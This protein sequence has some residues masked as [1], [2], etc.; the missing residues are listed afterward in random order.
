MLLS[1]FIIGVIVISSPN[2]V[3]S[4]EEI[5]FKIEGTSSSFSFINE[6]QEFRFDAPTVLVQSLDGTPQTIMIDNLQNNEIKD[7]SLY[8]DKLELIKKFDQISSI[9]IVTNAFFVKGEPSVSYNAIVKK[10]GT[11]TGDDR[12]GL[13]KA[14]KSNIMISK[15]TDIL[16]IDLLRYSKIF[17]N[18][19]TVSLEG[20]EGKLIAGVTFNPNNMHIPIQGNEFHIT[21]SKWNSLNV[22]SYSS[23]PVNFTALDIKG[24]IGSDKPERTS[25]ELNGADDTFLENVMGEITV[26]RIDDDNYKIQGRGVSSNILIGEQFIYDIGKVEQSWTDNPWIVLIVIPFGVGGFYYFLNRRHNSSNKT[27]NNHPILSE[28]TEKYNEHLKGMFEVITKNTNTLYDKSNYFEGLR[29]TTEKK[30]MIF[31]HFITNRLV[32]QK[33]STLYLI[34]Q[35]AVGLL[36]DLEKKKKDSMWEIAQFD[37]DIQK[38]E[39]KNK[40]E[41]NWIQYADLRSAMGIIKTDPIKA[42]L[43]KSFDIGYSFPNSISFDFFIFED[44]DKKEWSLGLKNNHFAGSKNK[45]DIEELK[46]FIYEKGQKL[47]NLVYEYNSGVKT[48]NSISVSWFNK[49]FR[50]LYESLDGD[51]TIGACYSCIN[52]FKKKESKE[53]KT[54]LDNFNGDMKNY[55]EELWHSEN[56]EKK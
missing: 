16:Q 50:E 8:N 44:K 43:T 36:N 56:L 2:I 45:E 33:Y 28:Y 3:N 48:V 37:E 5:N 49:E 39:F 17:V 54:I 40:T 14:T 22:N 30:R 24:Q 29:K 47:S 38:F 12:L 32:S 42:V 55:T 34:Y 11:E 1:L 26:S 7:F 21:A 35:T 46:N 31:Q 18:N 20:I 52:W 13:H 25:V 6:Q 15:E 41:G 4:E 53:Y 19:Q 27:Q 23:F 10:I 9:K 51:P